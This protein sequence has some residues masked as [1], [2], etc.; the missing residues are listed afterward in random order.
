MISPVE[1]EIEIALRAQEKT[2]EVDL[3]FDRS[4]SEADTARFAAR[5]DWIWKRSEH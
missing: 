3:H 4:D 5:P 1:I 2:Y